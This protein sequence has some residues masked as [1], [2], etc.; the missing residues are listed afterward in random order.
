VRIERRRGRRATIAAGLAAAAA[1]AVVVEDLAGSDWPAALGD[2]LAGW[3]LLAAAILTARSSPWAWAAAAAAAAWFAGTLWSPLAA[4]HRAPLALAVLAYPRLRPRSPAALGALA[5]AAAASVPGAASSDPLALAAGLAITLAALWQRAGTHALERRARDASL[6]AA[7]A[8]GLPLAAIAAVRIGGG[9]LGGS[10]LHLYE[11]A[12]AAAVLGLALDLRRGRWAPAA[13]T[14]LVAELGAIDA[15]GPLRARLA[16]ALGDP[17]LQVAFRSG[18]GCIDTTG[19]AIPVPAAGPGQ[20]LTP[21]DADGLLVH[22]AVLGEHPELLGAAVASAR[23][24]VENARLE[25]DVRASVAEVAASRRRLVEAADEQRR[26]LQ[27]QLRD[28]AQ[29]E[30]ASA[31]AIVAGVQGAEPLAA[32]LQRAGEELRRFAHGV[33]PALLTDHG[34]AAALEDV[35]AGMPLAIALELP[36]GRFAPAAEITVYYVCTEALA[37]AVKH[38]GATAARVRLAAG[39]RTLRVEVTDDGVG[40]ATVDP[41][42]GLQGLAD[43]VAAVGG[44]LSVDSPPGAGTR[45]AAV[46][47]L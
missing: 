40:G 29:R 21:I 38:A 32:E 43:R 18:D 41:D 16:S 44:T 4:L 37:N 35:T 33:H 25:A 9:D 10:G 26:R 23:L 20:V 13:V 27:A 28:G 3:A 47:P 6:V 11:A 39:A 8:F 36:P 45:V 22:D 24:A 31:T 1:A 42:G 2:G 17:D 14:G 12:V 46:V 5:L 19:A 34:L 15:P 7:A 30:L